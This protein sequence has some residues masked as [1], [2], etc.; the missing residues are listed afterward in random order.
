MISNK[1]AWAMWSIASIFYA[2]QYILRVIPSVL[3]DNLTNDFGMNASLFGQFSGIYYIGYALMHLPIGIMLD[4]FPTKII[5]PI[6]I[7][8]T[9]AGILP[10]ISSSHYAYP[11]AGRFITGIGSSAAILCLFKI[12]R[13]AFDEKYFT[14]ILS[15][16]VTIG[17]MGAIYGGAPVAFLSERLGYQKLVT[18]LAYAGIA[19][20][21]VSFIVIPKTKNDIDKNSS[22]FSDLKTIMKNKNLILISVFSGLMVG[23]LEGFADV[24]GKEFL[25]VIYGYDDI[26]APSLTSLIFIGMC[27]GSPLLSLLSEKVKNYSAVII[28]CA[29][30]MAIIFGLLLTGTLTT[31]LITIGFII[32]GILCSYQIIAIYYASLSVN[33]KHSSLATAFANMV[34]VAFGYI[35]HGSIGKIISSSEV[36][37][38]KWDQKSLTLGIS[39]IPFCLILA[40]IGFTM[41]EMSKKYKSLTA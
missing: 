37:D 27:I 2:Y 7:L 35:F 1:Q 26:I 4:R 14:R 11:I 8:L 29:V 36:I 6:F 19:L 34:I 38:G 20:A 12:I 33:T 15:I 39:I 10:L 18:I 3:I 5:M 21:I 16:A 25:K 31:P 9:V 24:W 41:L 32:V 17:L 13:M 28:F 40:V 30:T 22:L 23:P